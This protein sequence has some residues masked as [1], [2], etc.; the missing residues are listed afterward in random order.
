[1]PPKPPQIAPY[2]NPFVIGHPAEGSNIADR[3]SEIDRVTR[4]FADPSSR[5]VVYGDRRMGKTSVVAA[6]ASAA[7]SQ[8]TPVAVVDLAKVTSAEAAVQR[9]LGAV[10]KEIGARWRDTAMS[11]IQRLRPG[12][13]SL[14]GGLDATGSPTV[15]FSVT[16]VTTA[17]EGTGLFTDVLDAVEAELVS[18]GLSMGIALDEFQRLRFWC[19]HEI[20]WP[21]KAMLE[22]HR[23]ISYVLAGSERTLIAQMLD[24]KK[25]GLWKLVE[26]LDVQPIPPGVFAQWLT[27]RAATT[28][29]RFDA[30]VSEMV[31]RLAGPRSRDVVHLARVLW[32]LTHDYGEASTD[33]VATAMDQL[34]LEQSALYLRE[35]TQLESDVERK[36]LLLL[37][38]DPR[39]ELTATSTLRR[40]QLGP[41]TTV[42]RSLQR[43]ISGE[44]V[45]AVGKDERTFDDPFFRR[46]VQ[47]NALEDI[48]RPIPLLI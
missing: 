42:H 27:D 45:V 33:D 14:S 37:A 15:T 28:G 23:R 22:R 11:L 12:T 35:W 24:N 18:R 31:V 44:V 19:G 41:K 36:I 1:M 40:Y 5:I 3:N 4:A 32:E 10:H 39:T 34:V 21:L 13:V 25:A 47:V 46:W 30:A 48:G 16:P 17:A 2:V 38:D 26:I 43:L 20:D 29:V 9:V 6:A 7:K 8:G